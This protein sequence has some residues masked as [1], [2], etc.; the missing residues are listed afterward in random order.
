[1][2]DRRSVDLVLHLHRLQPQ[3]RLAQVDPVT[4]GDDDSGH[5]TGHRREQRASG[6]VSHGVGE[7]LDPPQGDGARATSPRIDP[8]R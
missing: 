7:A 1:M 8:C 2:P 5:G 4:D 6:G 3:Q